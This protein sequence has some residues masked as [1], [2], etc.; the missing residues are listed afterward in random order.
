[1]HPH[2]HVYL[3]VTSSS[4]PETLMEF[5][6]CPDSRASQCCAMNL[7]DIPAYPAAPE[8]LPLPQLCWKSHSNPGGDHSSWCPGLWEGPGRLLTLWTWRGEAHRPA[9]HQYPPWDK[10]LGDRTGSRRSLLWCHIPLSCS[11]KG[12]KHCVV[13]EKVARSTFLLQDVAQILSHSVTGQWAQSSYPT[14][15]GKYQKQMKVGYFWSLK[16]GF[17]TVSHLGPSLT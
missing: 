17:V 6:T 7:H 15:Q 13:T 2:T 4:L 16:K 3:I 12:G 11:E 5:L 14:C 9:L 8:L 10:P 1:M